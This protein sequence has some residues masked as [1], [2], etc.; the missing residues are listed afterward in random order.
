MKRTVA[1]PKFIHVQVTSK[2]IGKF[3][4]ETLLFQMLLILF[5]LWISLLR[6]KTFIELYEKYQGL[7]RT[8][9]LV[10]AYV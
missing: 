10:C 2:E 5:Y 8:K 6:K 4:N 1:L 9:A 3:R 7:V